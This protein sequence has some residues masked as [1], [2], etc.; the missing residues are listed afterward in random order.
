MNNCLKVITL[1]AAFVFATC[2]KEP[3]YYWGMVSLKKNGIIFPAEIRATNSNFSP[4]KISIQIQTVDTEG[5]VLEN[6]LFFKVPLSVGY[7]SLKKTINQPPDDTLVGGFY[8]NGYL[9]ELYDAYTISENDST[10][11]IE[12]TEY[13]RKKKQIWGRFSVTLWPDIKGSW[14]APDSLVFTEGAFHTKILE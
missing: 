5:H 2:Q 12:I 6:L 9:D 4:T 13:D 3:D 8:S 14:N 11:F 1:L 10:S 7:N